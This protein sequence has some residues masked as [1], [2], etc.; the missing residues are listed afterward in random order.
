MAAADPVA[1]HDLDLLRPVDPVEVVGQAVRVCRDP[2]HPLAKV[3]LEDGEVA[4]FGPPLVGDL[5]VREHRAEARAPV[6]R[7]LARVRQTLGVEDGGTLEVGEVVP[8]P[9]VLVGQRAQTGAVLLGQLVDRP[10]PTP[11]T[12]GAHGVR[13]VPGAVD[14]EEDPLRPAVVVGVD[15]PDGPAVVVTQAEAAQ[16]ARHDDD[17]VLGRLARVLPGLHGE[18]LGRE[19]EGV[20]AEAVQDVLAEHP[21][22]T[23][24]DVGRD[25]PQRV[26]DVEAGTA[27]VGKH[28]EDEEVPAGAG[29]DALRVGPRPGGVG[30]V[31]GPTLLPPVLPGDLDAP[32][33]LGGVAVRGL[34]HVVLVVVSSA[35]MKKPLA[36]EGS[37]RGPG[38][39]SAAV[40]GAATSSR[41]QGIAGALSAVSTAMRS[42]RRGGP[43]RAASSPA[44]NAVQVSAAPGAR[45]RSG[46][47]A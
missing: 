2:Q 31:V 8:L 35:P 1:L 28:V 40:E 30:R 17:V 16:L 25:V 37:P 21:V 11:A 9:A 15:G 7:C 34:A 44:T 24:E 18:L 45:R 5:L 10:R 14:L 20:V 26:P 3:A 38:G 12:V 47:A 29:G 39:L 32:G 23:C 6:D 13:V 19:P 42:R 22:E 46:R 43:P 27:R 41:P 33:Q 36:Q 4:A